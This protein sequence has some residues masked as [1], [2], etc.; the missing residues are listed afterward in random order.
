MTM[1]PEHICTD[2]LMKN[3]FTAMQNKDSTNLE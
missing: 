2:E 3:S 1:P